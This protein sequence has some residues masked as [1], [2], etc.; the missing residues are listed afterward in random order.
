MSQPC[1]WHRWQKNANVLLCVTAF[2][3]EVMVNRNSILTAQLALLFCPEAAKA[4]A[5]VPVDFLIG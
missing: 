5:K 1:G 4:L 2:H 3:R